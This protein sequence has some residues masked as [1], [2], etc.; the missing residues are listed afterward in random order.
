MNSTQLKSTW[1]AQCQTLIRTTSTNKS[2]CLI[3]QL[4]DKAARAR[5]S[6]QRC[7]RVPLPTCPSSRR[8]WR[9]WAVRGP[10]QR[11]CREEIKAKFFQIGLVAARPLATALAAIK[12]LSALEALLPPKRKP[13]GNWSLEIPRTLK[14]WLK[15]SS[16]IVRGQTL[17]LEILTI[18]SPNKR[19]MSERIRY[20]PWSFLRSLRSKSSP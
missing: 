3:L 10:M 4:L 12:R 15:N 16:R 11:S 2:L 9:T 14:A 20:H 19:M 6:N 1:E 8:I 13:R 18:K 7:R 5:R 17:M